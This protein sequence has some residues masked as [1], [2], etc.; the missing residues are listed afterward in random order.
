[1]V[2][3]ITSKLQFLQRFTVLLYHA[4]LTFSKFCRTLGYK[5]GKMYDIID[6]HAIKAAEKISHTVQIW[7]GKTNFYISKFLGVLATFTPFL[8]AYL[9]DINDKE[10]SHGFVTKAI[11]IFALTGM[12]LFF[13]TWKIINFDETPLLNKMQKGFCNPAKIDRG[14]WSERF[15]KFIMIFFA[16]GL[17][18]FI[19]GYIIGMPVFWSLLWLAHLF[20]ACDTL[21]RSESKIRQ[22]ISALKTSLVTPATA[23][24]HKY[25]TL[26]S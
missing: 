26:R 24:A 5:G 19:F 3:K 25:A 22:K 18:Y 17:D 15:S 13:Y 7:T 2:S 4:A 8:I 12:F 23:T 6:S 14:E 11:L 1:M 10:A 9:M 20:K 21:P 16:S